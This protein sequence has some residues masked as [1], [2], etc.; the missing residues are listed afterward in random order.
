MKEGLPGQ[1]ILVAIF[2]VTLFLTLIGVDKMTYDEVAEKPAESD[3]IG[4]LVNIDDITIDEGTNLRYYIAKSDDGVKA[5]QEITVVGEYDIAGKTN[6]LDVV[7]KKVSLMDIEDPG[8]GGSTPSGGNNYA[9][10]TN[11]FNLPGTISGYKPIKQVF[12]ASG[13]TSVK[14]YWVDCTIDDPNWYS[15][16]EG[17]FPTYID[18]NTTPNGT[19]V[20]VNGVYKRSYSISN[21]TTFYIWIPRIAGTPTD[22]SYAYET[23]NQEIEPLDSGG[24]K[25]GEDL[26]AYTSRGLQV[27]GSERGFLQ[28][29]RPM[30]S[31]FTGSTYSQG[32]YRAD[33][34]PT[35]MVTLI[36]SMRTLN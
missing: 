4:D 15:I 8:G 35:D 21:Y 10:L 2:I 28:A 6:R 14:G 11:K 1:D 13:N 20:S 9:E 24:Y 7:F 17:Y 12:V 31:N 16:E 32:L 34:L 36:K 23:S 29:Y 27:F 26:G 22:Y 18:S 3:N 33:F 25:I 30:T 5:T 19:T